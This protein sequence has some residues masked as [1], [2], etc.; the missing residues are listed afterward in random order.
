MFFEG[1]EVAELHAADIAGEEFVGG[2]AGAVVL[3]AV[4]N[5]SGSVP[6]ALAALFADEGLLI[7]GG[8]GGVL[9]GRVALEEPGGGEGGEAD[10]A[11]AALRVQQVAAGVAHAVVA[12]VA[13]QTA[14]LQSQQR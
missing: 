3:F 7:A 14:R 9:Q 4:L 10:P 6:V 1:L 11:A 5:V 13:A 2:E 12:E 8:V